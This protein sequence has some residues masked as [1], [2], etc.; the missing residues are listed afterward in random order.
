M[1]LLAI[2]L[3]AAIKKPVCAQNTQVYYAVQRI[4]HKSFENEKLYTTVILYS[5]LRT[6][7]R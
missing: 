6:K 7:E 1:K 3:E 5:H 2:L 4:V